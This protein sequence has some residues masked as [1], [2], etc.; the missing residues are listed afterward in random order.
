MPDTHGPLRIDRFRVEIDGVYVEGFKSVDIPSPRRSS[1]KYREGKDAAHK[2]S[3]AGPIDY[4][5]LTLERGV[6]RDE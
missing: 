6:R 2:K 4:P 1:E 5:D 3:L